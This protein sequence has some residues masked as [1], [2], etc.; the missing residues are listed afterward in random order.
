MVHDML[1]VDHVSDLHQSLCINADLQ[2]NAFRFTSV[3][4]CWG[5]QIST[6]DS[7][8]FDSR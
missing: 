8:A 7:Y 6:L 5:M 4:L 1:Q 2:A 3:L